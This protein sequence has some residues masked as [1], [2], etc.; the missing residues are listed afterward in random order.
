MVLFRRRRKVEKSLDSLYRSKRI[1]PSFN[2]SD[3]N[4]MFARPDI[5]FSS[6]ANTHC[7]VSRKT[8]QYLF[9]IGSQFLPGF[10]KIPT[11]S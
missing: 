2:A 3:F 10:F 8:Y 1:E 9:R 5:L 11:D 4:Q 6:S 7:S